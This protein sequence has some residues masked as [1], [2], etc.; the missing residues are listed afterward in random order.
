MNLFE[1][2]PNWSLQRKAIKLINQSKIFFLPSNIQRALQMA[3]LQCSS[4]PNNNKISSLSYFFLQ[5]ISSHMCHQSPLKTQIQTEKKKIV[6]LTNYK[7]QL[8][9]KDLKSHQL[10][11]FYLS[12]NEIQVPSFS[13]SL[14][15][16][17]PNPSP[18][19]PTTQT[20]HPSQRK[21]PENPIFS[22]FLS[23]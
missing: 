23:C 15:R 19:T 3:S 17:Q 12:R 9:Q 1:K 8:H 20:I 10:S 13:I 5:S 11:S 16:T 14:P 2:I 18:Q 6:F 7:H 22:P 4:I 21:T